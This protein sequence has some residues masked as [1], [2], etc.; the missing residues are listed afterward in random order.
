MRE[1]EHAIKAL[2][3]L[4][5]IEMLALA[6]N[7]PALAREAPYVLSHLLAIEGMPARLRVMLWEIV[8]TG[9]AGPAGATARTVFVF[10]NGNVAVCDADGHQIP[11]LQGRDSPELRDAIGERSDEQTIWEIQNGEMANG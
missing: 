4:E 10:A 5:H 8:K 2:A 11:E 3:G 7:F 6:R 9:P 1:V